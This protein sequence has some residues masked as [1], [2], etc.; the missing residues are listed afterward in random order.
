M[1]NKEEHTNK[2]Q[3][4]IRKS[5]NSAVRNWIWVFILYFAFDD[6]YDYF[7]KLILGSF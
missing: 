1:K 7:S 2:K 6:F 4:I 5:Q 3:S